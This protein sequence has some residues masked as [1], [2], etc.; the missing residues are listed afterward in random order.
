MIKLI[1]KILNKVFKIKIKLNE[2]IPFRY[3]VVVIFERIVMLLRGIFRGIGFNKYPKRLFIG[4]KVTLRYKKKIRVEK[5]VTFQDYCYI[6][7]LSR[8]GIYFG[9][10]V[11]IGRRTTIKVSGSL[12]KI[13]KGFSMGSFSAIGNDCYMGAAG[14][15]KIGS[16]VAIGQNVRFHSENHEFRNRSKRISEQG[17]TNEGIVVGDDC[18]IGAGSVVLDGVN[19]GEGCVIGANS[20]VTKDIPEYSIAVGNPAKIIGIRE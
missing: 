16:F 11:S 8:E 18:W 12:E 20:L 15:I 19:I 6:D 1:N 5:N 9:E 2:D 14:G 7:A 13:G 4:K 17:V 10:Q 3:I